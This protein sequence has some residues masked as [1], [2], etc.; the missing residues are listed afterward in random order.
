MWK[1]VPRN[2]FL[3]NVDGKNFL[4]K[5]CKNIMNISSYNTRFRETR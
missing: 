2:Q 1:A 5:I 4:P 3:E